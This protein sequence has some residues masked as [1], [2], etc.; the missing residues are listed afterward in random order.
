MSLRIAGMLA[1]TG[2]LTGFFVG[3]AVPHNYEAHATLRFIR[4][5]GLSQ[6][7]YDRESHTLADSAAARAMS[8][9][10]LSA[11]I[12]RNARL[13]EM[14]SADPLDDIIE[15]LRKGTHIEFATLP[16]HFNGLSV[17]YEDEVAGVALDMTR[18]LAVQVAAL[19]K[20][21][22]VLA[23]GKDVTEFAG[24]PVVVPIG[25]TPPLTTTLGLLIG[26]AL[27]AIAW[28]STRSKPLQ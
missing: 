7:M 18:D 28:V 14:L 26:L 23:D 3:L 1:M 9:E 8:A 15:R 25:A 16:G 10:E 2:A 6:D 21:S 22:N 11:F 20:S 17:R 19:A 27:G 12:A 13:R 24:F 4:P 5:A